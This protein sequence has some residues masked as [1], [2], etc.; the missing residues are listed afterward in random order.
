MD[1]GIC[2]PNGIPGVV[3]DTLL[4]WSRN[5]DELGFT[6]LGAIDRFNYGCM[7]PV[8]ALTAAAAVTQHIELAPTV[9]MTPLRERLALSEQLNG[10]NRL[11]DGRV[12]LGVGL[13]G[14][15]E[16]YIESEFAW[17]ERGARLDRMMDW[18]STCDLMREIP[19]V[20]GGG[21]DAAFNRAA[22]HAAGYISGGGPATVVAKQ[23][24]RV[25]EAWIDA[26]R[27]EAPLQWATSYF[28]LGPQEHRG[29]SFLANYYD[30]AGPFR[31]KVLAGLM[32]DSNGLSELITGYHDAGCDLLIFLPSLADPW[33]VSAL[34]E[35]LEAIGCPLN[36]REQRS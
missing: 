17:N 2:L 15:E 16:D 25:E 31:D 11:S 8:V 21:S 24:R 23:F 1:I 9:L 20:V 28:A 18:F 4:T 3:R 33:Q 10:L 22:R 6:L 34:A 30:D 19:L 32:T 26:G 7:E 36:S 27:T 13:G 14:R 5:A 35:E 29:R 12:V